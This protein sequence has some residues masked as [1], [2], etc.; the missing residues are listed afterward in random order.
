M[1][2]PDI[3][4]GNI[5]WSAFKTPDFKTNLQKVQKAKKKKSPLLLD[6]CSA[7]QPGFK[8]SYK[9]GFAAHPWRLLSSEELKKTTRNILEMQ[10]N[11]L[12]ETLK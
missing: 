10:Q 5:C 1:P 8:G 7:E 2:F 9:G 3:Y 12:N 4:S 11:L 6:F